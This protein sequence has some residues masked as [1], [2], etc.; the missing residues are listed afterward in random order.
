MSKNH[1]VTIIEDNHAY[2]EVLRLAFERDATVKLHSEFSTAEIALRE[3]DKAEAKPDL[4]LL[5]LKLPSMSGL[6]AI[7]P[8]LELCPQT[9]ILILSQSDAQQDILRAISRGAH[10]YLL[11]S[12][13]IKRITE[14]IASTCAGGASLDP[15]VASY[16]VAKLKTKETQGMESQDVPDLSK[17]E[18]EI[19]QLLANGM[20]KKEIADQLEISYSTVDTHVRHIYQKLDA[21][22]APAAVSMAH[23]LGLI[24]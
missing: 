12:A 20:L 5:D 7:W 3:L 23:R 11:K 21:H 9:K 15:S 10:G 19:L 2:R 18:Y 8:L 16:L 24:D 1:Q 4:I 17:R 13:S 6:D 22:N 14:H